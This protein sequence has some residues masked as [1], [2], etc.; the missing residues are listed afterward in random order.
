MGITCLQ[1][2]NTSSETH[3]VVASSNMQKN[4]CHTDGHN[5]D[6]DKMTVNNHG[7]AWSYKDTA[8]VILRY[9]NDSPTDSYNH[10][11]STCRHPK[12]VIYYTDEHNVDEDLQAIP[13]QGAEW[14]AGR[15]A[16]MF[17]QNLY[18]NNTHTSVAVA[19]SD[20]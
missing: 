9:M 18:L 17:K 6:E 4:H 1:I 15:F 5:V 2:M 11:A 19:S 14:A 20:I 13:M 16:G 8:G 10:V 12:L 7:G 3:N